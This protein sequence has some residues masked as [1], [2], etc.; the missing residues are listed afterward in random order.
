MTIVDFLR[1]LV[2]ALLGRRARIGLPPRPYRHSG[3]P[4]LDAT[5]ARWTCAVPKPY[6]LWVPTT[7]ATR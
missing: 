1:G 7:Y 3:A 5:V 4:G 2:E 6:A